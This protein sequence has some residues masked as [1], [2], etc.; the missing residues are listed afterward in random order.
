M[1]RDEKDPYWRL[2]PEL[3]TPEDEICH[4]S[5]SNAVILRDG[6]SKNPLFC[7]NCNGEVPPERLGFDAKFAEE[8]ANWLWL[9]DSLYCLWLNSGE[10]ELWAKA[11]LLDSVGQVNVQ[12]RKIVEKLSTITR[13]Y[14]WWFDDSEGEEERRLK[15]CPIC[16]QTLEEYLNKNCRI[17]EACR[18]LV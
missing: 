2:R 8:I 17:C 10:Y 6:L 9:Y 5:Q 11:R 3:P 16:T 14:Y 12:G 1:E 13:T 7:A 4:C 18:I 15:I